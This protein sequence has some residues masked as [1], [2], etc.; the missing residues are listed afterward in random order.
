MKLVYY[1]IEYIMEINY[2]ICKVPESQLGLIK[3]SVAAV[4]GCGI[5]QNF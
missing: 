5:E 4:D 1:F 2:N 3:F